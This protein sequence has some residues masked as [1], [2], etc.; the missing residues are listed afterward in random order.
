MAELTI[1]SINAQREK[2]TEFAL[3]MGEEPG[4]TRHEYLNELTQKSPKYLP[5]AA[6]HAIW[7]YIPES[8]RQDVVDTIN[9]G[10][11]G[12]GKNPA[13]FTGAEYQTRYTFALEAANLSLP[14][15]LE[16]KNAKHR[17]VMLI[18]D[19]ASRQ[20]LKGS[21]RTFHSYKQDVMDTIQILYGETKVFNNNTPMKVGFPK[22]LLEAANVGE[23]EWKDSVDYFFTMAH[24]KYKGSLSFV[25]RVNVVNKMRGQSKWAES[26]KYGGDVPEDDGKYIDSEGVERQRINTPWNPFDRDDDK[27]MQPQTNKLSNYNKQWKTIYEDI[28][29]R[30]GGNIWIERINDSK[31]LNRIRLV[32]VTGDRN[33]PDKVRILG[34][35]YGDNQGI[36]ETAGF[37]RENSIKFMQARQAWEYGNSQDDA[38]DTQDWMHSI[39]KGVEWAA[40]KLSPAYDAIANAAFTSAEYQTLGMAGEETNTGPISFEFTEEGGDLSRDEFETLYNAYSKSAW[41]K[42]HDRKFIQSEFE[43]KQYE[44]LGGY[45]DLDVNSYG[46]RYL[47]EFTL[48]GRIEAD[49][50][51]E[52]LMN[53]ILFHEKSIGRKLTHNSEDKEKL[54][55]IIKV[56]KDRLNHKPDF[57]SQGTSTFS[58]VLNNGKN[59]FNQGWGYERDPTME[60]DPGQ[61]QMT[62]MGI[63]SER[64]VKHLRGEENIQ[65]YNIARKLRP[66]ASNNNGPSSKEDILDPSKWREAPEN[67]GWFE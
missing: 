29:T 13:P 45:S 11:Q 35:I 50:F 58:Y 59:L 24:R 15:I 57:F 18:M 21:D 54:Y 4:Y 30:G 2:L 1:D 28:V 37:T 42:K 63:W 49:M 62:P 55:D 48:P 53:E 19:H 36:S 10:L 38:W 66:N 12:Y 5:F 23:T 7:D 27:H 31:D 20:P 61:F 39:I 44:G 46:G 47:T 22:R 26:M 60:L 32:I 40:N 33:D 3:Q 67:H 52:P 34:D 65:L 14:S 6:V 64:L 43:S 41:E 16:A 56:V 8:N 17:Q 25:P 9:M 51:L